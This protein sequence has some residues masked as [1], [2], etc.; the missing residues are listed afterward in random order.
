MPLKDRLIGKPF[1]QAYRVA[2]ERQRGAEAKETDLTAQTAEM[3][4]RIQE[5]LLRRIEVPERADRTRLAQVVAE[6]L[7]ADP[8]IHPRVRDYLLQTLVDEISGFGPIQPLM[9]DPRVTEIMI[10]GPETIY[11]ERGGRLERTSLRFRNEEHLGIVLEKMLAFTGRR[12]DESSPLVDARLPDGSR[13]HAVIHPISV[14]GTV[15]TIRKFSREPL[16]IEHLVANGTLSRAMATYLQWAVQGRLNIVI[17]GGTASGKTTTLNAISAFIGSDE[18]IVSIEDAAEL[19]LQ[20]A[21]WVPLE[22]RPANAEGRG[23]VTIRMLVRN[24]LRMRPDRILVGEVRGAEALDMLQ[25]MN[26]GHEGSLTT[27]HAN[28]PRDALNRLETMVL[29]AGMDLPLLAIRQQIA[30]AI[31]VV[32][33]QARLPDGSRRMVSIAEIS[34]LEEGNVLM[35]EIFRYDFEPPGGRF[36]ATGIVSRFIDKMRERGVSPSLSLFRGEEP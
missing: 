6:E 30:S 26:T 7:D 13:L 9:D 10:N 4:G 36:R 11:V 28:S 19:R 20:Q 12:I 14:R 22:A 2:M 25:A 5:A 18:R 35:Q 8:T 27:L 31:N 17:S 34:G 32:V 33:Q 23:E 15:V 21:H 3:R 29:M 1:A 16:T 24:A